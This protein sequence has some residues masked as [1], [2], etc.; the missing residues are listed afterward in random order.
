M[1]ETG[2][3]ELWE[4]LGLVR[5]HRVA[6]VLGVAAVCSQSSL[7][8]LVRWGCPVCSA[9][10]LNEQVKKILQYFFFACAQFIFCMTAG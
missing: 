4:S 7:Q 10:N 9:C 8:C 6:A 3:A 1:L 2:L 5:G